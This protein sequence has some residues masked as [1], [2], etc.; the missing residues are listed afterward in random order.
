MCRNAHPKTT[1]ILLTARQTIQPAEPYAAKPN[2]NITPRGK[3]RFCV[4]GRSL[5]KGW[6]PPTPSR[7]GLRAPPPQD[8]K[9]WGPAAPSREGFGAPNPWKG[10]GAL[11]PQVVRGWG[12]PTLGGP[13]APPLS[14]CKSWRVGGPP[15]QSE[16]LGALVHLQI[17][18]GWGGPN[19][20]PFGDRPVHLEGWGSGTSREQFCRV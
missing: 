20:C 14:I 10:W 5:V 19:P 15:P 18:K 13:A 8:L 6:W 7:S 3:F 9:G 2:P 1:Q 12:A 11:P 4:G 16:G 17:V